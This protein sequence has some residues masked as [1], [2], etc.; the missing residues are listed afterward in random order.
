MSKQLILR[1]IA[2]IFLGVCSAGALQAE[3]DCS[4]CGGNCDGTSNSAAKCMAAGAGQ[5]KKCK[6]DGSG[7]CQSG[8]S[9]NSGGVK[10][11]ACACS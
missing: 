6:K 8:C 2:C 9:C 5:V 11:A 1:L 4:G 7:E 10:Y 3:R